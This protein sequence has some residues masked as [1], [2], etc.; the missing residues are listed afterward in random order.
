VLRAPLD[1]LMPATAISYATYSTPMLP[2]YILIFGSM[3]G[4]ERADE[5]RS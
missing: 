1:Q 2:F 4:F 5:Q 3:F